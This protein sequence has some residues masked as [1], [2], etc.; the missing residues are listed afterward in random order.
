M[1]RWFEQLYCHRTMDGK[2]DT[3]YMGYRSW[4]MFPKDQEEWRNY[5]DTVLD[6]LKGTTSAYVSPSAPGR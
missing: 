2:I 6:F 5:F 3:I 1:D 4:F